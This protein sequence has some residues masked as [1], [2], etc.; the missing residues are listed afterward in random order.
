MEPV[1][2]EAGVVVPPEEFWPG[3]RELTTTQD[4]ALVADEIQAGLGRTGTTLACELWDVQP[5]LVCLGKALG[6]GIVPVSAVIGKPEILGVLTAGTH[7]STFGGNPLACAVGIAALDLLSTGQ[8]QARAAASGR[9]LAERL[10]ALVERGLLTEARTIGLWA[11]IDLDPALGTGRELCEALLER[12]VLAKDA[13]AETIRL[14]PPLSI[15][16]PELEMALDI[17]EESLV[18]LRGEHSAAAANEAASGTAVG[19]TGEISDQ[20]PAGTTTEEATNS[21]GG[22]TDGA[23]AGVEPPAAGENERSEL[24]PTAG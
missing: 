15:V 10:D 7:G 24:S 5:D 22:A 6:G 2:G 23:D 20:T 8:Y 19:T 16:Q 14:S 9:V 18:A 13:R 1:Q 3:L 11:G 17:L 12:G 21:L 4:I